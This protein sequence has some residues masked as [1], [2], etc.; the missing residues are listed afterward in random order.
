MATPTDKIYIG[1]DVCKE[2]LD[3]F[4]EGDKSYRFKNTTEGIEYLM[5][6][7]PAVYGVATIAMEATGGLEYLVASRLQ[8]AGYNVLVANPRWVHNF[9]QCYGQISK[10][11]PI[12]AKVLSLFAR[13]APCI[14]RSV[15][16]P[17]QRKIKAME[18]RRRQL[19]EQ[20]TAENN[21]LKA[22]YC[23]AMIED[24]KEHLVYLKNKLKNI[25]DQLLAYIKSSPQLQR[26]MEILLSIPG[27]GK[28]TAVTL[29]STMPELGSIENSKV[30]ALA[31]LAPVNNES[32]RTRKKAIPKGGRKTVRSGLYMATLSAKKFNPHVKK[33]YENLVNKGKPKMVALIAAMRKLLILANTLIAQNRTFIHDF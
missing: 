22:A 6:K 11:D 27:I 19:V 5:S 1:I 24:I 32:G 20:I 12:D 23:E 13:H 2:F 26:I 33:T 4:I 31:G 14:S 21:R 28:T 15:M 25:I 29:I 30:S 10:T 7:I 18:V 16:S 3:V 17:E 8:D 9:R